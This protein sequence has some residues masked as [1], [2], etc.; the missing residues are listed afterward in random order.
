[1]ETH[2]HLQSVAGNATWVKELKPIGYKDKQFFDLLLKE[3]FRFNV[4]CATVG[5]FSAYMAVCS[6]PS[7]W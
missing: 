1:M 3:L 5:T 2:E 6:A 7:Q 4:C